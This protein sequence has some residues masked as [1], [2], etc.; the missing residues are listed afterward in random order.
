M[1]GMV[2]DDGFKNKLWKDEVK[3]FLNGN[4]KSQRLHG[5]K[6]SGESRRGKHEHAYAYI[7]KLVDSQVM[8]KSAH[9]NYDNHL[10]LPYHT[11]TA[12][13][14]E[15][16]YL[17]RQAN[18]TSYA[19]RSTFTDALAKVKK[20]KALIGVHIRMSG[21]KGIMWLPAC[22]PPYRS[23]RLSCLLAS[24]FDQ[25]HSTNATSATMRIDS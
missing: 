20:D 5:S 17:C 1:V 18:Q 14:D 16:V 10:Y 12:L 6:K 8:D 7:L 21:G 11:L 15:Y 23:P 22:I 25:A 24:M 13:F 2:S 3:T 9:A 19:R 4:E